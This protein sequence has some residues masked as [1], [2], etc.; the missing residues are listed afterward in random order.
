MSVSSQPDSSRPTDVVQGS[1][2]DFWQPFL[3]ETVSKTV[4]KPGDRTLTDLLGQPDAEPNTAAMQHLVELISKLRSSQP[5]EPVT[6]SLTPAELIP[7]V[8]DEA[9]DVL[10]A[11]QENP[12]PVLPIN[13]VAS[14]PP[15]LIETIIPKLLW[16]IARSSY[17]TMQMI[18]GVRVNVNTAAEDWQAGVLRLAILL[19]IQTP[20]L[21]WSIDLA[22]GCALHHRLNHSWAIRT[23]DE[24]LTWVFAA[25]DSGNGSEQVTNWADRQLQQITQALL[26][27]TPAFKALL[28]NIPVEL[29]PPRSV[30]QSGHLRLKLDYEFLPQGS[31][32]FMATGQLMSNPVEAELIDELEA[33]H[34]PEPLSPEFDL[35]QS[36]LLTQAART[37]V[38]VVEMPPQPLVATTIVRLADPATV[39]T[40]ADLAR[41]QEFANSINWLRSQLQVHHPEALLPAIVQEA[42]RVSNMTYRSASMNFSLLQPELL[43]DE[44]IPK[45]LWQVTRSSYEGTQWIGGVRASLLQPEADWENGTLRLLIIL[46][47]ETEQEQWFVDLATG[48]FVAKESWCLPPTAIAQV[49]VDPRYEE[50]IQVAALQTRLMRTIRST[51]PEGALLMQGVTVEWLTVEH[52]WQLGNLQIYVGLEFTPDLF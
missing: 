2:T 18:E 25:T 31:P 7:Y 28:D 42:Y 8:T 11:L 1:Q 22:T 14:L 16:C 47:L 33:E 45:L 15:L 23:E 5:D 19:E 9:Y 43:V 49:Q 21:E 26:A 27:K 38:A 13:D 30:W 3:F 4:L 29:M 6:S 10:E 52:D 36:T 41:Q 20:E 50:L 46:G 48:R 40:F 34:A 51:T 37:P 35:P 39:E 44:V 24:G 17:A 32:P 12:P